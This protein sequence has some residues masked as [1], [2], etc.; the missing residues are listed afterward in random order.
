VTTKADQ[1][2]N[3]LGNEIFATTIENLRQDATTKVVIK[4]DTL[5]TCNF[6]D[7]SWLV[8]H[9]GFAHVEPPVKM[10]KSIF[11]ELPIQAVLIVGLLW[12][13]SYTFKW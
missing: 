5:T 11:H 12:L 7:G 1:I 8:F 6:S 10:R 9:D 2:Y 4:S 3:S 13:L